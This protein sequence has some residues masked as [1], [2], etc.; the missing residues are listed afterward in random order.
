MQLKWNKHPQIARS[1]GGRLYDQDGAALA[2]TYRI[3]GD[4]GDWYWIAGGGKSRIPFMNTYDFPVKTESE[5]RARAAEYIQRHIKH[6]DSFIP[7]RFDEIEFSDRQLL[8]LAASAIYLVG[9]WVEDGLNIGSDS[10]PIIWNPLTIDGDVLRL[11]FTLSLNIR[12][13]IGGK[14]I[15]CDISNGQ[16]YSMPGLRRAAVV[17]A[18]RIGFQLKA[19]NSKPASK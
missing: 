2:Y 7:S 13:D 17:A 5:A 15:W 10:T 11:C 1:A 6:R 14:Y 9:D 19:E 4:D 3:D 8:E 18:A 12:F 16:P